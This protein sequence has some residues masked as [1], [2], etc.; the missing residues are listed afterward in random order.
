MVMAAMEEQMQTMNIEER[1]T[2]AEQIEVLEDVL[3]DKSNP[4]KFTRIRT[5]M[6]EKTKQD[7]VQFLKKNMDVFA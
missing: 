4:K 5:S 2:V 6:K 3:L 7:L 1:R